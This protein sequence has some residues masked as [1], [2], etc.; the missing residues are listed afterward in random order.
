MGTHTAEQFT[1]MKGHVAHGEEVVF[2]SGER[3]RLENTMK[4]WA[5]KDTTGKIVA[6]PL[7]GAMA[8]EM[9]VFQHES[10]LN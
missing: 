6:G 4:G 9:F 1:A 8:V 2:K 5:F 3:L 10:A 7:D